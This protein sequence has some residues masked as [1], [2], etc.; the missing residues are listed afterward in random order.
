M[1]LVKKKSENGGY[2]IYCYVGKKEQVS[3]WG[4]PSKSVDH[5]G[6]KYLSDRYPVITT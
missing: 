2:K 6:R 3:Y 5:A 1:K 4:A